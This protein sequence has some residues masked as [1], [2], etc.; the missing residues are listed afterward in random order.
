MARKVPFNWKIHEIDR[1]E[2]ELYTVKNT[3]INLIFAS[4]S[5]AGK[6]L[7]EIHRAQGKGQA[8]ES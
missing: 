6:Y 2:R 5:Y 4:R 7:P 3:S 1:E 8:A